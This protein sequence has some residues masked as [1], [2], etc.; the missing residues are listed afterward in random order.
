ML[1]FLILVLAII[2]AIITVKYKLLYD[3]THPDKPKD[4]RAKN[5]LRSRKR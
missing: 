4:T 3:P 5:W 2:L 1:N